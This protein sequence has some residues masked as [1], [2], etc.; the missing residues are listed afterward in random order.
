MFWFILVILGFI[1]YQGFSGTLSLLSARR[2]RKQLHAEKTRRAFAIVR[3]NLL[4]EA[5]NGRI[6]I[7]GRTFRSI[8]WV[9]TWFMREM[10]KQFSTWVIFS[11]AIPVSKTSSAVEPMDSL[12]VDAMP[13]DLESA[14]RELEGLRV[15]VELY[16]QLDRA[17]DEVIL[18]RSRVLRALMWVNKK[19][20]TE[21]T[22]TNMMYE[23]KVTKLNK[24][25]QKVSELKDEI[26][27]HKILLGEEMAHHA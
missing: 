12:Q 22:L 16:D 3:H 18:I 19:F 20:G 14:Q 8:Y 11:D 1:A 17:I 25:A 15:K 7:E 13:D 2:L 23:G 24:H 27:R 21:K 5:A 4:M 6:E 9:C 10:D 26:A